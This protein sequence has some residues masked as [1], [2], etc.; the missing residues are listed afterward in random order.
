MKN[1]IFDGIGYISNRGFSKYWGV[2]KCPLNTWRVQINDSKCD[3]ITFQFDFAPTEELAAK[4]ASCLKKYHS[5]TVPNCVYVKVGEY[6][7]R[8]TTTPGLITRLPK[9]VASHSDI[10]VDFDDLVESNNMNSLFEEDE[11]ES[12]EI[13]ND[14]VLTVY[15]WILEDKINKKTAELVGSMMDIVAKSNT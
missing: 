10:H 5:T 3:N 13:S 1:M 12:N 6:V 8:I 14:V 11:K 7:Y 4:I 9:C 15:K 2:S